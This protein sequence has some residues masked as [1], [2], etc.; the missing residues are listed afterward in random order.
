MD[1]REELGVET[2]VRGVLLLEEDGAHAQELGLV[3]GGRAGCREASVNSLGD[4]AAEEGD[5]PR[6]RAQEL[7]DEDPGRRHATVQTSL[8]IRPSRIDT[9]RQSCD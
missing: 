8:K 1:G 6:W 5:E 4:Q 9:R 3:D 2:G 7:P